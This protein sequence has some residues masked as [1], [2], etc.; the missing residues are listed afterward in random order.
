MGSRTNNAEVDDGE[1]ITFTTSKSSIPK[2]KPQIIRPLSRKDIFYSGSVVN[3]PEYQSQKSLANYRQSVIS[4]SKSVRG[5]IKDTDVEKAR[6]Q[7]LCPCLVLPDSFKEALATMMDISLL[8]NPVFLL[9]GISNVF[10]MAGLYVPFVYLVEAAVK[11]G[12]ERNSEANRV[13]FIKS[14][15]FKERE[16]GRNREKER[17]IAFTSEPHCDRAAASRR[18]ER[19]GTSSLYN[20]NG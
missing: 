10:G 6:Q 7:P 17:E 11:D 9:I 18:S 5:D 13:C 1:S 14:G 20:F 15:P 8:K 3:L 12:I 2:E 4:L 19:K 16:R